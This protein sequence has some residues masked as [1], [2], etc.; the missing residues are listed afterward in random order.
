MG[1]TFWVELYFRSL[2]ASDVF[3]QLTNYLLQYKRVSIPSVGT[4]QLIQ[5]PAQLDA[6]GKL[7]L[8]PTFSVTIKEN[9]GVSEHQ[10]SFLSA[11][12]KKEKETVRQSLAET[13]LWLSEKINGK[14]FDWKGIGFIQQN[15]NDLIIPAEALDS[16][17]AEPVLQQDTEHTIQVG[18]QQM[19]AA[20]VANLKEKRVV[21]EKNRSIFM[22]IGWI[23]LLLA[24]L[25]ILFV[26]YQGKFRVGASG[27]KQMPTG[28]VQHND[29]FPFGNDI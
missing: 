28:F 17:P 10:L 4:I 13:G 3:N 7:I 9:G 11:A 8:P 16:V 24:I 21:T 25:Y 26:L 2:K 15:N 27:S 14:G 5:Q 20:Q 23:I 19:T 1:S 22:I 12:L 29:S 18:D 6:A